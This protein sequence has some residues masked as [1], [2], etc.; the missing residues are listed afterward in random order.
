ML[1]IIAHKIE[2]YISN[3]DVKE[4]YKSLLMFCKKTGLEIPNEEEFSDILEALSFSE[5]INVQTLQK[6]KKVVELR[7][8]R[9]EVLLTLR[10]FDVCH[11]Y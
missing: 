11:Y 8:D 3:K 10:E 7:V 6:R 4:I 2:D 9:S 1:L 5:M